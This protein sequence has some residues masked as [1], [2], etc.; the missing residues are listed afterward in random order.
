MEYFTTEPPA[1]A[2]CYGAAGAV[3]EGFSF[4]AHR[5]IR[6]RQGYGGTGAM[7]KKNTTLRAPSLCGKPKSF[8]TCFDARLLFYQMGGVKTNRTSASL[9]PLFSHRWGNSPL[10]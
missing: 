8:P 1:F 2:K 6:R 10:K 7:G 5:E 3:T 9:F 4:F